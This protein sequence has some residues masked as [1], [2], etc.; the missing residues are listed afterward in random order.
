MTKDSI[1]GLNQE[2]RGFI[3]ENFLY[4]QPLGFSDQDSFLQKGIID[5]TGIVELISF[6]EKEYGIRVE[7]QEL[8]PDNLDSIDNLCRFVEHKRSVKD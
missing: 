1:K 7:D 4:G 6:L 3:V 2:L 8:I 5:S